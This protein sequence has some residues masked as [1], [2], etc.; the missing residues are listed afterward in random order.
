MSTSSGLLSRR[1]CG[2]IV[3]RAEHPYVDDPRSALA[4]VV[5]DE[6]DRCVRELPVAL[7]LAHHQLARVAGADD[8]HFLAARD[9]PRPRPLDQ[10]AREEPRAR[11]EREQEQKVERRDAVRQARGVIRRERVENEVRERRGDDDAAG[12]APHV[13]G[14]D[15]PPPAVVEAGEHER[16]ELDRDDERDDLPVEQVPIEDRRRLVEAE[17]E[18]QPPRGDDQ[19]RVEDELPDP[20]AIDREAHSYERTI[21]EARLITDTTSACCSS[22]MPAQSGRQRFSRAAF[23]VSGKSPSE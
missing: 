9:D 3:G 22:S 4:G 19:D 2:E 6:P 10:R 15:V 5:V 21:C 20:V 13:T 7:H 14:R 17:E 18:R 23:S 1:R 12:S 11:D 16:R 8:Q